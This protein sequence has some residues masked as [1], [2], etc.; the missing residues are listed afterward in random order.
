METAEADDR[1]EESSEESAFFASGALDE[2]S[3]PT[4]VDTADVP[5]QE[6]APE[7]RSQLAARRARLQAIVAG[8]VGGAGLLTALALLNEL[9]AARARTPPHRQ[10]IDEP[11][12]GTAIPLPVEVRDPMPPIHASEPHL[13]KVDAR[14]LLAAGRLPAAIEAARFVLTKDATD[15]ETYLLLGAALQDTGRWA[16]STAV[17]NRCA[18]DAK[19]GPVDECRALA[20]R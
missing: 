6:H 2:N 13:T 15:A 12:A 1:I 3:I 19:R 17:F 14:R 5:H 20:R 8:V 7:A 9:G 11:A 18:Q 16:E 4:A 10:T